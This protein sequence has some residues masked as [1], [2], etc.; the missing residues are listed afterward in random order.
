MLYFG[1]L[2]SDNIILY[3]FYFKTSK[4]IIENFFVPIV[5]HSHLVTL[6]MNGRKRQKT[7][8]LSTYI[9]LE[10]KRGTSIIDVE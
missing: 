6:L 10:G 4:N 1:H 8:L 9:D 7:I 5:N 2:Q 3:I